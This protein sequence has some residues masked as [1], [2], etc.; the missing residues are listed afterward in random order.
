M[1]TKIRM[2]NFKRFDDVE[3]ELGKNVVFIGPNNSGKTTALQALALWNIGIKKWLEKRGSSTAGKGPGVTVNRRDLFTIPIPNANLLWKNI[4]VRDVNRSRGKSY[5]QNVRIEIYVEGITNGKE[6]KCGLEFDYANEE[7]FYCR[8]LQISEEGQTTRMPIPE[9]VKEIQIAYLPPM[10]G[11]ADREFVKLPGEMDVLIGQG[12]TAQVLRNLCLNVAVNDVINDNEKH[13]NWEK[14]VSLIKILFGVELLPP[15]FIQERGEITLAYK[16]PEGKILDISTSGRGLHQT[17]L[18]FSYLFSNPNSILLLD[19]P[20]AHLEVLRQR[21]IYNFLN[22]VAEEQNSQI[23]IASHSEVVLNEAAGRDMVIAFVGKPHRIDGRASQVYK[24][25]INIGFDQYY[26]AE[27]KGWVLYLEG[28]TD[29]EILRQFAKTLEH[30]A[31]KCLEMPFVYY[32]GTNIPQ[33]AR[34]HFFGLR[35]AKSD[36]IGIAI[37][38]HIDKPLQENQPLRE[39]MWQ[40]REIEN[41]LLDEDVLFSYAEANLEQDLFGYAEAQRRRNAMADSIAEVTSALKILGKPDP[42]SADI[43][44]SDEFLDPLFDRYFDKIQ[45]PNLLRKSGYY[46]LTSLLP[47]EKINGE[48]I[49]KLDA[50]VKIDSEAHPRKD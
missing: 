5:T 35:E 9:E 17:L 13:E 26:Q 22:F 23:I 47:K 28:S 46:V 29:L 14:L 15:Q 7:S 6:W 32:M 10:S 38:D 2:K 16:L 42:W 50:I 49:E 18:L 21:Q 39:F 45:L 25:L 43:K 30:E 37:F 1:L 8:P 11:M 27:Q 44:A 33:K 3:F 41:Y 4:H 20:D 34:E 40:K 19:E 48:I 12:Q 36:L 31:Y 24:S